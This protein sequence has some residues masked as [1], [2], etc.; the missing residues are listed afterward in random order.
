[1]VHGKQRGKEKK[2]SYTLR[3]K[4]PCKNCENRHQGCHAKCSEYADFK[5]DFEQEK[6]KIKNVVEGEKIAKDFTISYI[7]KCKERKRKYGYKKYC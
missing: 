7:L 2:M 3:P 1:M 6:A 4:P 5:R